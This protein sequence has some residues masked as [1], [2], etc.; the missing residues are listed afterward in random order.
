MMQHTR[1]KD[2]KMRELREQAAVDKELEER[3]FT[4]DPEINESSRRLARNRDSSVESMHAWQQQKEGRLAALRAQ[5][6]RDDRRKANPKHYM[7]E[8]T[9]RLTEQFDRTMAVEEML[10]AQGE[11]SKQRINYLRRLKEQARPQQTAAR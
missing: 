3:N 2:E 1:E 11:L 8:G 7:S 6:D 4:Y 10:I 9:R 5:R